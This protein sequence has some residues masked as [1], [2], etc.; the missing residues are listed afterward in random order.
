MQEMIASLV[1]PYKTGPGMDRGA[2][3]DALLDCLPD[4]PD[5]EVFLVDDGSH[6]AYQPPAFRLLRLHHL[7]LGEG[8]SGPGLARNLGLARA[9]GKWVIFAD[10]DDLVDR[11]GLAELLDGLVAGRWDTAD[12]IIPRATSFLDGT[13][14]A[15]GRRHVYANQQIERAR[16]RNDPA[17]VVS[18]PACWMRI[19]RRSFLVQHGVRF[20]PVTIGEDVDF[21]VDLASADPRICFIDLA[22]PHIRDG[23][24]SL[25]SRIGAEGLREVLEVKMAANARLRARGL[26][27][28]EFPLI[29][30]LLRLTGRDPKAGVTWT[31][32]ALA[33]RARIFPRAAD[34]LE[35]ILRRIPRYDRH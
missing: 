15:P 4:R 30:D 10:S 25:T 2:M 7:R 35:G 28:L 9:S 5:L 27:R 21:A 19:V 29:L 26:G 17:L 8:Q 14:T 6:R 31:G 12:M 32:R 34:L 24:T 3:M 11:A 22:L 1:I 18:I 23:H 16:D 20:S 33:R 13:P